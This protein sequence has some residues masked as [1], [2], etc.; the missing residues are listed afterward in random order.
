MCENV[1]FP[2]KDVLNRVC[3]DVEIAFEKAKSIK[4][5]AVRNSVRVETVSDDYVLFEKSKAY[6]SIN[7]GIYHYFG[8]VPNW[9]NFKVGLDTLRTVNWRIS[10]Y[11]TTSDRLLM[12]IEYYKCKQNFKDEKERNNFFDALIRDNVKVICVNGRTNTMQ[13][14]WIVNNLPLSEEMRNKMQSRGFVI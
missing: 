12:M 3:H 14:C 10:H 11:A 6:I 1:L 9:R 5:G 13:P 2:P 7:D 4:P 8:A